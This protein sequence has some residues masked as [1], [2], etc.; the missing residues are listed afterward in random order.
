[1][2]QLDKAIEKTLYDC[3]RINPRES[4]LILIDEF[5][6]E[7][8]QKFLKKALSKKIDAALLEIENITNRN[9]E[10]STTIQKL[11]RQVSAVLVLTS[12]SLLHSKF[13]NNICYNGG[14]ILFLNN[15]N[16]DSFIRTVNIDFKILESTSRRISDL[17]SICKEV[18]LTTSAGTDLAFRISR[19]K[20]STHVCRVKDAGNFCFLPAGEASVTPDRASSNGMIV[21]DGSIPGIGII[22]DPIEIC[23]K[24]GSG[25]KLSG[26]EEAEK[27]RKILKPYGKPSRNIAE[28]GIGTN[29]NA[30]ITGESVEDEKVLGTAHIALGNPNFEGGSLKGNLHVDLILKKPTVTLDGHLILKNGKMVV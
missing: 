7:I 11:A 16:E 8:G 1:M 25:Y 10:P 22:E 3:L 9:P 4:V 14:R 18:Y 21:V 6:R 2:I 27:L 24:D 19:H 23:V 20:G 28:F 12:Y 17:F 15:I 13:K 5:N 26:K 29:P 30:I